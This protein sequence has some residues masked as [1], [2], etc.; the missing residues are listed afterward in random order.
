MDEAAAAERSARRVAKEAAIAEKRRLARL[1]ADEIK[2]AKH[3]RTSAAA[4]VDG[5]APKPELT[6]AE[7]KA[8]RDARYMAR[9]NR[10]AS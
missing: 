10:A 6:E 5:V 3:A 7:R 8:A 4:Q 1:A 9:K 2:A